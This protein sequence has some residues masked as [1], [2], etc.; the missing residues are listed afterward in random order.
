MKNEN[1]STCPICECIFTYNDFDIK[2]KSSQY[3]PIYYINCPDCGYQLTG[4][5]RDELS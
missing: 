5:C 4:Y 1:Q 2:N 3:D